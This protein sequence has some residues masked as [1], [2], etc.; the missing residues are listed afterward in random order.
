MTNPHKLYSSTLSNARA[1]SRP[2]A[3]RASSMVLCAL[4]L[5]GAAACG[6]NT[7]DDVIQ[8]SRSGSER[9]EPTSIPRANGN[10]ASVDEDGPAVG[11]GVTG[12]DDDESG[13]DDEDEITARSGGTRATGGGGGGRRRSNDNDDDELLSDA[14]VDVDAGDVDGGVVDDAGVVVE[15]AGVV[16]ED[17]GVADAG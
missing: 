6:D 14:G 1:G 16:E 15:D 11:G 4:G 17:A 12:A 10:G 8:P 2:R 3:L 7:G 9:T 5:L 13:L